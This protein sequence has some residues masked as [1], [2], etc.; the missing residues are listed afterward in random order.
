VC[1]SAPGATLLAVVM[2]TL[3]AV[4]AAMRASCRMTSVLGLSLRVSRRP[5][6]YPQLTLFVCVLVQYASLHAHMKYPHV[7]PC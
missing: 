5:Q 6:P 3:S 7:M 2:R 1:C 4:A